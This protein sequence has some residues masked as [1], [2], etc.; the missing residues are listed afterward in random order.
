MVMSEAATIATIHMFIYLVCNICMFYQR[1]PLLLYILLWYLAACKFEKCGIWL[2]DAKD[3]IVNIK[4]FN[5]L[6]VDCTLL[7]LLFGH[8]N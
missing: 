5:Y 2:C 4:Q 3:A 8:I 6:F 7:I 1:P